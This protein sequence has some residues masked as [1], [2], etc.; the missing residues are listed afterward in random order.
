MLSSSLQLVI[1]LQSLA[2]GLT[3]ENADS[4][5]K[6]SLG[7]SD[8]ERRLD[9]LESVDKFQLINSYYTVVRPTTIQFHLALLENAR[10]DKFFFLMF[11]KFIPIAV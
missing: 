9:I 10:V 7:S 2:V 1:L 6:E 5:S 11:L 3:L 8:S 4:S